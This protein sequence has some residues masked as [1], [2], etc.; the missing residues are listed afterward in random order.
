MRA[1]PMRVGYVVKRY[2]R[3]SETFIV[4]EILAHEAAGLDVEVFA[5]YPPND[6]HFQDAIAR[7]RAPVTYLTA[8][9]LRAADL[10]GAIQQAG[11]EVPGLW[12]R[13]E[14][15]RGSDA[16]AAYQGALLSR[17]VRRSGITH[18]HAHFATVAAEVARLAAG[19][20]GIPYT[21]T[22][23]AKD[24]FHESVTGVGLRRV[25][26]DAAQVVTVSDH[27]VGYLRHD[28]GLEAR[29]VTRIY[30]GIDL[31]RFAWQAPRPDA[32][33]HIISVGRFVEKK[34][35]HDLV[36]ACGLL[37]ARGVDH[38]CTLVGSGP[39]E[40]SLR[41]LVALRELQ[42]TVHFAGPRP[43][44]E[45]IAMVGGAAVFA[46]PCRVADDGDRDGLPTVL[47][48]AMALGTPVVATDV[49]GIPEIVRHGETGL[50]VPERDVEALAGALAQLL[51][52]PSQRLRLSTG[53]RTLMERSFDV[54][55]NA[56]ALRDVFATGRSPL[57]LARAS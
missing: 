34:G 55:T 30:N 26:G 52:S 6:T 1:E 5:L 51:G 8:E 36:E 50:L 37:R 35:L 54:A 18:L 14:L 15:A 19:W 27:N 45:V 25:L 24:I 53:A 32:P 17:A 21:V 44:A 22:A 48:E 57:H 38:R 16:R 47:L 20:A 9:G 4:N 23:H 40:P 42:E 41:A 31:A 39:L 56:A 7:V 12:S 43:Q 10:W 49:V 28:V 29:G 2:P 33:P 3:F 11:A 13:L 46:A